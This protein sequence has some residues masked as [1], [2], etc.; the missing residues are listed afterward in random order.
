MKSITGGRRWR[1]NATVANLKHERRNPKQIPRSKQA[2]AKREIAGFGVWRRL[3]FGMLFRIS[4]F[5]FHASERTTGT[6]ANNGESPQ[7]RVLT[8]GDRFIS[9]G[10]GR[11]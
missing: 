7:P 10:S 5:G 8:C 6:G 4:G 3:G 9:V 1:A 2:N 11:N